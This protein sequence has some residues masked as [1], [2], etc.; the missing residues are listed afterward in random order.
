MSVYCGLKAEIIDYT[1]R[2]YHINIIDKN[3]PKNGFIGWEWSDEM[4]ESISSIRKNLRY[5]LASIFDG[6]PTLNMNTLH[7]GFI[8]EVLFIGIIPRN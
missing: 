3:K 4:F 8:A 2:G 7:I 6:L 5:Y 1:R